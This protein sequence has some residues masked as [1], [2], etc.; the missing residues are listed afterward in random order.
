MS[1]G[2]VKIESV[3]SK[4]SAYAALVAK[5]KACRKCMD[6]VNP[7]VVANGRFDHALQVGAWTDWQGNLESEIMVIGQEWGGEDNYLRQA[8]RDNDSDATN[9]NLVTLM[10]KGMQRELSPPSAFQGKLDSGD[11]FFTNAALC[12]RKGAAT[13]AKGAKNDISER[14]F[15]NCGTEFLRPQIELI[16]PRAVLVLGKSAWNGLMSAFGLK[17]HDSHRDNFEGGLVR[18]NETTIAVPLYHC[19]SKSHLNRPISLQEVDW[20]KARVA[21]Q[22]MQVA[23]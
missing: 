21:I 15:V 7:A 17:Y 3:D 12:L 14:S 10:A 20:S 16:R 4:T 23:R 1:D 13:S 6:V 2:L 8:G 19:G 11:Y 22:R 5:R 9:R 18:L